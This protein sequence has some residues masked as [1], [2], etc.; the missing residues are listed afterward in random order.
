METSTVYNIVIPI[1]EGVDLL[2]VTVPY[3]VF[4][5]VQTR[6]KKPATKVYLV[7]QRDRKS[8]V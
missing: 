1:Y 7:G 5:W 8:V 4:N 6:D 3:E 2:D